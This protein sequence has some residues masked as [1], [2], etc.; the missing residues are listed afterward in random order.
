VRYICLVAIV[1]ALPLTASAQQRRTAG[2][3]DTNQ[4][5]QRRGERSGERRSDDR[6]SDGQRSDRH[7]PGAKPP[8]S[9][10]PLPWWERQPA[11]WWENRNPPGWETGNVARA[12]L[13]QQR[14]QQQRAQQLRHGQLPPPGGHRRSRYYP[15]SVVYV[16]PTYG[17]FSES[18]AATTQFAATAPGPTAAVTAEPYEPPPLPMGALRL[19]VEPRESLQIFVDGVYIGTPADLGGEI[20][21][22]PGTRRIELRARGHRT[23]VFTAEIGDGRSITYRGS[24]ESV[25]PPAPSTDAPPASPAPSA[26]P[27]SR[28]MYVI[29]GCYLGNVSPKNVALPA[30]CDLSKLTTISP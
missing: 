4:A 10:T 9:A 21:L 29:P 28:V 24:L 1:L 26:P 18:I 25:A 6:K 8:V 20:E 11:P 14:R 7:R 23:L 5:E 3:S 16:L 19:E 17:Y 22:A 27:G 30:G 15:P 13:D 2:R 12:L